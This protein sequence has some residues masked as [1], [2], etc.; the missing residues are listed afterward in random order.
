[1]KGTNRATIHHINKEKLHML[2]THIGM[3][4]N[5]F[6][7]CQFLFDFSYAIF[8]EFSE[9]ANFYLVSCNGFQSGKR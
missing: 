9:F 8:Y 6:G 7:F 3:Q 5:I 2:T 1:M 4:V